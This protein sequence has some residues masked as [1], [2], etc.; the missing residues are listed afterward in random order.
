MNVQTRE[1]TTSAVYAKISS[2]HMFVKYIIKNYCHKNQLKDIEKHTIYIERGINAK[3]V[4]IVFFKK[5]ISIIT[6]KPYI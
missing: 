5:V 1:T 4:N 3:H 2:K 6:K